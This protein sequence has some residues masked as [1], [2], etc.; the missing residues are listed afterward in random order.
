[1]AEDPNEIE[2]DIKSQRRD[3]GNHI[4]ELESRLKETADWKTY[5]RRSP[6]TFL[7]V[8]FGAGMTL[9]LV[10]GKRG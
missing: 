8:A 5:V 9:A 2:Q 1:M 3:L 6:L 7:T 4:Q 10:F